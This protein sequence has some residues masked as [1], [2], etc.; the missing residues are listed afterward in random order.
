VRFTIID[1]AIEFLKEVF[2]SMFIWALYRLGRLLINW[3]K[4]YLSEFMVLL[5]LSFHYF[6]CRLK[7]ESPLKFLIVYLKYI[8]R[9]KLNPNLINRFLTW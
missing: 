4:P 7:L 6:A 3:S 5:E 1:F 8:F 2:F 9:S